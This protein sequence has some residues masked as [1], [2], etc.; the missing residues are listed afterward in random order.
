MAWG[1]NDDGQLGAGHLLENPYPLKIKGLEGVEDIDCG[2]HYCLALL[3]D[4]SLVG[5]GKNDYGQLGKSLGVRVTEPGA[6]EL[7]G[8]AR[9]LAAGAHQAAAVLDDGSLWTWGW[10]YA[11]N[12]KNEPPRP[13]SGI[14]GF[15]RVASGVHYLIMLKGS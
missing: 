15:D 1:R 10:D 2:M 7:R 3:G 5:W 9:M 11:S 13:V 14:A 8:R 12:R 6:I 4:G